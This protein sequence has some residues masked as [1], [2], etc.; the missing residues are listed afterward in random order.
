MTITCFISCVS[1]QE[2]CEITYSS[3]LFFIKITISLK[4]LSNSWLSPPLFKI[5]LSHDVM[6]SKSHSVLSSSIPKMFKDKNISMLKK[7]RKNLHILQ[8][9]EYLRLERSTFWTPN[10]IKFSLNCDTVLDTTQHYK[11][12]F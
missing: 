8:I 1:L 3:S 7:I 11:L 6:E 4:K 5:I 12:K 10:K 2:W 9:M